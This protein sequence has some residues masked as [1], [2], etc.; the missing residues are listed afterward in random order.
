MTV[1][2]EQAMPGARGVSPSAWA[3]IAVVGLGVAGFWVAYRLGA[4][5]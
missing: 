1:V 3:V 4:E 5:A 2:F